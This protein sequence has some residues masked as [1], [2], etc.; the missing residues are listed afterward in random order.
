MTNC[1]NCGAVIEPYKIRC[2]YCGS[3]Y[4]DFCAFD[5]NTNK[6]VYV[7]FKTS[8]NGKTVGITALAKPS[9][10]GIEVSTDSTYVTDA[11]GHQ[12]HSYAASKTCE[13]AAR[14]RCIPNNSKAL[15]EMELYGDE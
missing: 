13:I 14:F 7:K 2:D 9:L 11:Y 1:P 4:F 12:L 5:C 15:F 10:E 6:P 3:F 8:Y